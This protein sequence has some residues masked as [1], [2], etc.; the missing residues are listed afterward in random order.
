MITSASNIAVQLFEHQWDT[1]KPLAALDV[2]KF[3]LIPHFRFLISLLST[4]RTMPNGD[5]QVLPAD[6]DIFQ[7]IK[8]SKDVISTVVKKI[9]AKN[10]DDDE[11]S[12]VE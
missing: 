5:L 2:N 7:K 9:A 10:S 12:D 3:A 8:A 6:F 11:E 4:P 1:K